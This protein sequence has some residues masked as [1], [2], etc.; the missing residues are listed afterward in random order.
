MHSR[1]RSN[2][3]LF[4]AGHEADVSTLQDAART[5]PWF[6]GAQP[7]A[8]WT[9][10]SAQPPRPRT[11]PPRAV[12]AGGKRFGLGAGRRLRRS[13]Q[14]ERLLRKGKRRSFAGYTVY[15]ERREAGQPRLGILVSRKHAAAATE[16]NR[17]KRCIREVFRLEQERLGPIDV[18]VRPPYR[19]ESSAQMMRNLRE[20]FGTLAS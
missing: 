4:R 9:R 18:L 11:A 3:A 12:A 17:I 13:A 2:T 1:A 19:S 10:R 14:F 6:S 15:L 20:L 16:R 7:N 8:R 5:A